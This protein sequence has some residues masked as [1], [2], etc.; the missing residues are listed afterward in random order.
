MSSLLQSNLPRWVLLSPV[1][2]K[3]E[4]YLEPEI[5]AAVLPQTFFHIP[6]RKR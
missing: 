5:M 2:A 1:T 3:A 6:L 4:L